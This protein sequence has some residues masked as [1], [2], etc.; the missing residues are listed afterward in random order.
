[1]SL[2]FLSFAEQEGQDDNESMQQLKPDRRHDCPRCGRPH[3]RACLCAALPENRIA[4]QR[5]KVL[6]LQH[7]HE[8]KRKNR[9]LFLAEFCLSPE[10]ITCIRTRRLP[11]PQQDFDN[12]DTRTTSS[13]LAP[14]RTIWLIFPHPRAKSLSQALFE[15]KQQQQQHQQSATPLT[16]IFLDATWKFAKEMEGA[17]HFPSHTEYI[18]LDASK[19]LVGIQPKRFDIRTPPS[20]VHLCTAECLALVA[21]RVEENPVIYE[22]IMRPLDLM[23]SQ[24]HSF[25]NA[26]HNA[27]T[28]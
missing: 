18:C 9:S 16:L 10:S 13:L 5:C 2:D 15:R 24:W 20:P 26:K 25:A 27:S 14:D 22:T 1:M 11:P 17:S 3:P 23:V 8:L 7:P 28:V 6:V 19:D 12:G 21:S 4:L